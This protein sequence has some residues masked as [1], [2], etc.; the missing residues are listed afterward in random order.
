VPCE[1]W[2]FLHEEF[3]A[4]L[5]RRDALPSATAPCWN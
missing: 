3:Y 4:C 5:Q 2:G 1:P